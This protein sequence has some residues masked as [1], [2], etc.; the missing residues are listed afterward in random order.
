[1]SALNPTQHEAQ[2]NVW[3]SLS[4][5]VDAQA[6]EQEMTDCLNMMKQDSDIQQ[7]WSEYFLIGEAMRGIEPRLSN[8]PSQFAA[9]L[10]GEPTILAPSRKKWVPRVVVASLATLA[11]VGLI[12]LNGPFERAPTQMAKL[13]PR[14]TIGTKISI[15]RIREVWPKSVSYV[16]SDPS[17]NCQLHCGDRPNPK[18]TVVIQTHCYRNPFGAKSPIEL[19]S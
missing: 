3:L 10:A 6:S 19:S 1:M 2:D 12:S 17:A 4:S 18:F 5:M 8:F 15:V 16:K 14:P 7:R 13:L 11:V 9:R